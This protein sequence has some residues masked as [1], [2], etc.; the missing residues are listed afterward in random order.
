MAVEKSHKK[1]SNEMVFLSFL[2]LILTGL[3]GLI[4]YLFLM[5]FSSV[6]FGRDPIIKHGIASGISRLGGLA[7]FL[8]V[9]IG[10]ISN[11]FLLES[12]SIE[13]IY[14]QI[15]N[16]VYF[17]IL[18]GLIG[19]AEDFSQSFSSLARL[20]IMFIFVGISLKFMPQLVPYDLG[21]F[22]ILGSENSSILV[23]L[24]TLIMVSGFINAGNI[25][26]GA[27]GLLASIF[28]AFFVIMYSLDGSIFNFSI[29]MSLLAFIIFNVITGRIFLGDFGAYSLSALVAFKALEVYLNYKLSI[30]LLASIL[31]YPCFELTRSLL[32]RLISKASLMSPDN[33]HLHNYFN[34]YL[35]SFGFK[36]HTTNSMTGLGLS[37][38][39]SGPPLI[40]Y[41][42]NIETSDYFW[43]YFFL[44]QINLLVFIYL[45]C[46]KKSSR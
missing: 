11:L 30:F 10:V 9:I 26:D 4:A 36:K 45:Y 25:A 32:V 1:I 37:L 28:L 31:I 29:L 34:D 20:V 17:S 5:I 22:S 46:L 13:S 33:D 18:I 24:F 3:N 2:I 23:F 8:S 16:I 6:N 7:I 40:I 27:N 43:V 12:L 15:D 39:T 44:I 35:L 42:S 19:L 38:I 14:A 21:L 41:F